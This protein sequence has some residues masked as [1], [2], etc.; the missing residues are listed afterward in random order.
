MYCVVPKFFTAF[1]AVCMPGGN[2]K[3]AAFSLQIQEQR[4]PCTTHIDDGPNIW[5]C[6][7]QGFGMRVGGHSNNTIKATCLAG[8]LQATGKFTGAQDQDLP[9]GLAVP[10]MG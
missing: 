9:A 3:G 2:Q 1:A 4:L 6:V 10:T 7:K 8:I 5:I